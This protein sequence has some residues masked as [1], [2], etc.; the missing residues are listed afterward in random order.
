MIIKNKEKIKEPRYVVIGRNIPRSIGF[1]EKH[2]ALS[3]ADFYKRKGFKPKII[4]QS[5]KY[6]LERFKKTKRRAKK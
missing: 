6:L 4:I 2:M 1:I 5:R 3:Y